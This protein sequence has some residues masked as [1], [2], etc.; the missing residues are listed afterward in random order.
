MWPIVGLMLIALLSSIIAFA[1]GTVLTQDQLLD[2]QALIESDL[3]RRTLIGRIGN[4]ADGARMLAQ[5]PDVIS[6]IQA[7]GPTAL[8]K[9]NSRAV[10]VGSRLNLDVVQIYDLQAQPRVNLMH[11]SL[12]REPLLLDTLDAEGPVVQVVRGRVLLLQRVDIR[13]GLGT[14]ITGLDMETE[15]RR[16][17][18]SHRLYSD[19]GLKFEGIGVSTLSGLPLEL[20]DGRSGS[21]YTRRVLIPVGATS[22]EVV[23]VR[24]LTEITRVTRTGLMVMTGS[25]I[26]T[27]L[28]LILLGIVLTRSIIRPIQQLA[29]AAE[30]VAQGD[31]SQ[32]VTLTVDG[33]MRIGTD[34]E[35]GRLAKVFNKMV[36]EL[37]NLYANMEAEVA[38][39]T[40]D[41]AL[42]A[43]LARAIS[44]SLDMDVILEKATQTIRSF[45]G[46]D[47]VS[48]FL[49]ESESQLLRLAASVGEMA[50]KVQAQ[51]LELPLGMHSPVSITATT[52]QPYVVQNFASEPW[53]VR[54][55]FPWEAQS[56][57]AVPIL[58]DQAVIGVLDVQSCRRDAFPPEIVNLLVTCADQIAIGIHNAQ[59]YMQQKRAAERLAEVDYLKTQF[60]AVMSHELRTPL[61]SIIGFSKVLLKGIDGPIN[62][63]QAQD[64]KYIHESGQHLLSLVQ[65]IIDISRIN[66]GKMELQ[67]EE[68]D[69]REIVQSALDAVAPLLQEK[70]I[71]LEQHIG[72]VPPLYADRRR[73][74]QI[75][76]NLLSNAIKFTERGFISVSA[77]TVESWNACTER[78]ESFVQISVSDTGIGI[79]PDRLTEIFE[80][81]TQ[82]D[83]SDS[84]SRDGAGLGL[85]I[86][87]KLIELHGG[88]IWVKSKLGEGSTFTFTLPLNS[89]G[90]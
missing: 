51:E 32:K 88:R 63:R 61:N 24:H 65:D 13:D 79:P 47:Y 87:K 30:A 6:A 86:T 38:V 73:L 48:V 31:L 26:L 29:S 5:D 50:Q 21:Y 33:P 78:Q 22:I 66:A 19:L 64:L 85:P 72:D 70:P 3:V 4:V 10:L 12:Y 62:E 90:S 44:S 55:L 25:M 59:L 18:A 80:E 46:C 36:A 49:L 16:L 52:C 34:D 53:C 67:L 77:Q 28:L 68:V 83:S 76:L 43:E 15:L 23:L 84:R 82:V 56:E 39:C 54:V 2:H 17:V 60:L 40:R 74:R 89:H 71:T 8:E 7:F 45:L 75:L 81:F 20:P 35:I 27:T 42:V 37:R 1:I 14:V 58:F 11:S 69:L 57:V 9:L 41:L